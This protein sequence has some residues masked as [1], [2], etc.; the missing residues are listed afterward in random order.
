MSK[1]KGVIGNDIKKESFEQLCKLMCTKQE[2]LSVLC[3]CESTLDAWVK[4]TY[5]DTC[6]SVINSLACNGKVKLRQ[7]QMEQAEKNPVMAIWLGKQYLGQTDK[8]EN[9]NTN[10]IEF[11]SDMP[12]DEDDE[13]DN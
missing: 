7:I 13:Y 3:V 9:N 6:V 10:K 12:T 2:I 8:V 11:I 4:K 5:G 1:K